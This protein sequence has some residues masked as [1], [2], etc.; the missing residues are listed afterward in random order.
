M[1][2]Q[3]LYDNWSVRAV[4]DLSEVPSEIRDQSIGAKVPGC[5]HTDLL[6]AGKFPDPYLGLNEY[7]LQ[8]IGRTDWEYRTTFDAD[9]KLFN[10][11][12]IDLAFGGLDTVAKIELNG[13]LIGET[14]NMHRSYRLDVR[15][16]LKRG[17]NELR[18]TFASA[19]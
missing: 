7:K 18:V 19:V 6:R 15:K 8:W 16:A 1:I 4:G 2:K 12:R 9:P 14:Q 17:S 10:H 13:T 5:I 3:N 11:E